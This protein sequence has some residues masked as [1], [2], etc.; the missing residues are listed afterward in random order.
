MTHNLS[1]KLL[2]LAGLAPCLAGTA[3]AQPV[4]PWYWGLSVGQTRSHL[5]EQEMADTALGGASTATGLVTD[6]THTGYRVFG[7]RQL[8][9]GWAME[10]AY[11]DLGN[12]SFS[13]GT[14]AGDTLQGKL[15]MQGASLDLVGTMP[16]SQR[17]ALLGR[18]GGTYAKVRNTFT[19][20][21]P[22]ANASPSQREGNVKVGAGLQFAFS[23]GFMMRTEVERYR[24][25][26]GLGAR[27]N[28]D[29]LSISAVFPFGGGDTRMS[30]RSDERAR[31]AASQQAPA[32]D[33]VPIDS[34]AA[35]ATAPAPSSMPAEVAPVVAAPIVTTPAE[36]TVAAQVQPPAQAP[37]ETQLAAPAAP[38]PDPDKMPATS[39]GPVSVTATSLFGFDGATVPAT[40]QTE[41][42]TFARSIEGMRYE[43][44]QVDGYTDRL[45]SEAYNQALSQRRADSVKSYLVTNGRLDP[46]RIE[47]RARSEGTPVTAKGDC[48][49]ERR[50]PALVECLQPDRRVQVEVLGTR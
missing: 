11:F 29:M 45:G 38:M 3:L 40:G 5:N 48:V 19:G 32:R 18:I 23:P 36:P 14:T 28:M 12:F 42:T 6:R 22:V 47:T 17:V 7:G 4:S 10:A 1:L 27:G 21:A 31:L 15:K 35:A 30:S 26:T 43:A 49:G 20:T 16:L 33:F 41:L 25:N 37:V 24:M 39:A 46:A 34:N 44:I 50:T 9:A 8:G 13:S 2:V